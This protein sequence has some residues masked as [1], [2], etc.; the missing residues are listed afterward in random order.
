MR[1]GSVL[2]T[3]MEKGDRFMFCGGKIN[4]APC[5]ERGGSF[6]VQE[7][8]CLELNRRGIRNVKWMGSRYLMISGPVESGHP[9]EIVARD[10]K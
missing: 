8:S 10:G 5:F 4:P 2:Q 3:L 1:P 7:V 6:E 9:F